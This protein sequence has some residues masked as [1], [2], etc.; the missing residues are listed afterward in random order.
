MEHEKIFTL[1]MEALDDELGESGQLEMR[2]HLENCPSCSQE[3]EGI[4]AI[5][6]LFLE[7]PALS[8]AAGFT[9]RTLGLLPNPAYRLWM[10]SVVYGL[11]LISGLLPVV[12]IIWLTSQ[13]GPALD[14]PAFVDG[15]LRAGG[16]VAQL[17]N[18]VLDAFRHGVVNAGDL[19]GQQPAIIG[20]LLVMV[21]AIL[22]WG[23]VYSQ[24]TNP[25]RVN[26]L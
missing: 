13:F 5:H 12:V 3:W 22:L 20:L 9:Q 26:S 17:G 2:T 15:V 25:R 8:P 11:L 23:G 10:G 18:T 24:L 21:G 16:Q 7:T 6:Q 4:Q 1:M 14:Q 19:I